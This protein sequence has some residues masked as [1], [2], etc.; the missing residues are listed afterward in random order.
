MEKESK[1][2]AILKSNPNFRNRSRLN[3]WSFERF[4]RGSQ[5]FPV[6]HV[7]SLKQESQSEEKI[8]LVQQIRLAQLQLSNVSKM[9]NNVYNVQLLTY[10]FTIM[11]YIIIHTYYIYV[12][13][14]RTIDIKKLLQMIIIYIWN[15]FGNF[16]KITYIAY[17][18]E[19][20]INEVRN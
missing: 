5:I 19:C 6:N 8:R 9:T 1:E 2:D 4:L 7:P 20:T 17:Y 16:M 11:I 10:T 14:Q 3:S 13:I 15:S 12:E 18:C